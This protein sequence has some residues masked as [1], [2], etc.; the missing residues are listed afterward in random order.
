MIP[1][2]ASMKII[3]SR[4]EKQ[5]I[6]FVLEQG[7]LTEIFPADIGRKDFS[8][9]DIVVGQVQ[10]IVPGVG[11]AFVQL[12]ESGKVPNA[13][14]PFSE[15]LEPVKNGRQL[16]VQ[17]TALPNGS[18]PAKVSTKLT[19]EGRYL[20]LHLGVKGIHVSKKLTSE[21]KQTL[22]EKLS[23]VV[24][25]YGI[26]VRT[27]AA[28]LL[29]NKND[30]NALLPLL[31]ELRFLQD[32]MK[33]IEQVAG[34]RTPWSV[35][36]SAEPFVIRHIRRF[37]LPEEEEILFDN[38][39][40]EDGETLHRLLQEYVPK[41]AVRCWDASQIPLMILHKL[42]SQLQQ[43]LQKKVWL[44]S[45]GYLIIEPTEALTAID[46]NSGKNEAFSKTKINRAGREEQEAREKI[47]LMQNLEAAKEAMRQIRLRNLSGMIL[48]D[49]VNMKPAGEEALLTALRELAQKDPMHTRVVDITAL[50]LAEI[51]RKK[52]EVPI[53]QWLFCTAEDSRR[54]V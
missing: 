13:C 19:L 2:K 17:I 41:Q 53:R 52:Q 4:Y 8:V 43:A 24:C 31:E 38:N 14:L 18:K 9:G 36:H 50:G 45:G 25:P 30:S 42:S 35:L 51:T 46:V 48:I 37:H 49:F 44:P 28:E 40:Q 23:A 10:N 27:E 29:K 5:T 21:E 47:I 16:P 1:G 34:A 33:Q 7:I 26:I 15:C 22:Q 20:V 32:K 39:L 54:K 3:F 6:G 11:A 12:T